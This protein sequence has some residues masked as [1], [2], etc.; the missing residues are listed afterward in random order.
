MVLIWFEIV[1]DYSLP[2]WY[3]LFQNNAILFSCVL[4]P[5][6]YTFTLKNFREYVVRVVKRRAFSVV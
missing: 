3:N 6:I 2:K 1:G 4:N 5:V